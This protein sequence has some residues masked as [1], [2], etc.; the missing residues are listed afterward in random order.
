[1]G[2]ARG[3]LARGAQR[4][5]RSAAGQA[6]L[7]RRFVSGLA[8]VAVAT[9]L[10]PEPVPAQVASA[11]T[12]SDRAPT[13]DS[14]P[15]RPGPAPAGAVQGAAPEESEITAAEIRETIAVLAHDSL[16]G[17]EAGTLGAER[18]A[19]YVAARFEALGLREPEGGHLQAFDLPAALR[20]GPGNSLS[21]VTSPSGA[22]VRSGSLPALR[23][24]APLGFSASAEASGPLVLH[25]ESAGRRSAGTGAEAGAGIDAQARGRMD[26]KA[27]AGTGAR[28]RGAVVLLAAAP[29]EAPNEIRG[30]VVELE[31]A[32]AAA[33]LVVSPE[34]PRALAARMTGPGLAIPAIALAYPAAERLADAAGFDLLAFVHGSAGRV[35]VPIDVSLQVDL[36]AEAVQTANVVGILEG[37]DPR[38]REEALVIGAHYDHLGWGGPGSLAPDERAI[39]NGADDN[40]SGVAGMLELAE[41]LVA[42]PPRRSI[43]FVAFGAE[44]AGLL[45]SL[46]YVSAPAWPLER[47]VAM[48]N[49]DMIGRLRGRLVVHGTGT[50][51]AWPAV[52]DSVASAAAPE[53]PALEVVRLPEGFGPS[54]HAAFYGAGVPVLAFFTGAHEDYHRPSDDLHTIALDGEV[55]VLRLVLD[56]IRAVAGS[57]RP[58]PYTQAPVTARHPAAFSVGLGIIPDY[59]FAGPGVRVSA[60]RPGGPAARA[61]LAQ[62]DVLLALDGR[63]IADIYGYTDILAGL[64]AG[65][66]VELLY[67]RGGDQRRVIVSPEER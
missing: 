48:L 2:V 66:A 61:R 60:V 18:A 43:V 45:G 24:F 52:L 22:T 42:E 62:G 7:P 46:H 23:A 14:A 27:G 59:G 16:E 20:L 6:A 3:R 17:R 63:E 21:F 11:P 37:R 33:V 41:R 67:D 4:I 29:A 10:L 65:R 13:A 57:D 26:A 47:T 55:R 38:L 15:G 50:S 35:A 54:D 64:Q 58:I 25:S 1:M 34:A 36:G 56:V 28:L 12:T 9:V 8:T 39:H 19:A 49:L 31:R 32:G 51:T 44:E 40:A 5:R 53:A 30:R